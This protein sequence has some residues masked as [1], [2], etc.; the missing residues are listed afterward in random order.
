MHALSGHSSQY[1]ALASVPQQWTAGQ[2]RDILG[3]G[4]SEQVVSQPRSVRTLAHFVLLQDKRLAMDEIRLA[5]ASL[6]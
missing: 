3:C 5:G 6:T 1:L 2:T 4:V